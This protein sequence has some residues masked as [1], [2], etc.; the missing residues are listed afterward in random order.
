MNTDMEAEAVNYANFLRAMRDYARSIGFEGQLLLEPKPREPSAYAQRS[1]ASPWDPEESRGDRVQ[2]DSKT[3]EPPPSPNLM[4]V[5]STISTRR[6]RW[7][8]SSAST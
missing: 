5:T 6:R 2:L 4:A 1:N 7:A 8:S 3:S